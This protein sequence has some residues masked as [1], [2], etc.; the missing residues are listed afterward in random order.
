MLPILLSTAWLT[1]MVLFVA[2][3]RMAARGDAQPAP[4]APASPRRVN[5]GLVVW[6][7]PVASR[8]HTLRSHKL[9]VRGVRT[10]G[11]R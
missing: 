11:A 8:P 4:G 6:E 10:H 7:E 9:A 5:A 1:V 3:C 2:I